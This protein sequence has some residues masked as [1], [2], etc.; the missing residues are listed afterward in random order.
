MNQR[1]LPYV[2]INSTGYSTCFPD[3]S[4]LTKPLHSLK[5][6]MFFPGGMQS[7]GQ[8]KRIVYRITPKFDPIDADI[9]ILL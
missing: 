4:C 3:T 8:L 2:E 6:N 1:H 9:C 7:I 5:K